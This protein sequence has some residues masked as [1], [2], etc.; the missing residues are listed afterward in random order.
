MFIN[1]VLSLLRFKRQIWF[2]C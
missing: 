2:W 1:S